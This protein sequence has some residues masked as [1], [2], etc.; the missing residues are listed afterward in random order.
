[1]KLICNLTKIL[2]KYKFIL[3]ILI[4][5]ALLAFVNI[6]L[7]KEGLTGMSEYQYLAPLPPNY[8]SNNGIDNAYLTKFYTYYQQVVTFNQNTANWTPTAQQQQTIQTNITNYLNGT[9]QYAP[10]KEEMEYYLSNGYFPLNQFLKNFLTQ[11][12][13]KNQPQA[14]QQQIQGGIQQM[15]QNNNRML[16]NQLN[17]SEQ[18][19]KNAT[20]YNEA[21]QIFIGKSTTGT[22]GTVGTTGTTG[23]NVTLNDFLNL[24]KKATSNQ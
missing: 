8:A 20:G 21:Y 5:F 2:M 7:V 9:N 13:T 6:P 3:V 12:I 23:T 11:M 18:T 10:Y 16:F 22:T 1:M 4:I 24:C 14:T 19:F 15:S 17:T